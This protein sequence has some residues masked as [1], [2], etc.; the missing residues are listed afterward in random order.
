MN[1][2]VE[3]KSIRLTIRLLTFTVYIYSSLKESNVNFNKCLEEK[4]LY[5]V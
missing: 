5:Q 2:S 4:V 1:G 3:N